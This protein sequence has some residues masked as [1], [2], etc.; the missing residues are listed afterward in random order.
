MKRWLAFGLWIGLAHAVCA[1]QMTRVNGETVD[2]LVFGYARSQWVFVASDGKEV[3]EFSANVRRLTLDPAPKVSVELVNKRHESVFFKG[4]EK[5]A[6]ILGGE[7]GEITAPV[8][9]LKEMKILSRPAAPDPDPEPVVSHSETPIEQVAK[10]VPAVATAPQLPGTGP[11]QW[12]QQG[13]WREMQTPGLRILS[14]GEDVDIESQLRKGVV[15]VIHF[16]YAQAHS[17]VRQG[18]YVEVLSRKSGGRVVVQRIVAP[19]WNAP[20]CKAKELKTLPQFWFYSRSGAL[21]SKLTE[22]FTEAD[23]EAALRKALQQM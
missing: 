11:R 5:F 8:T 7:S 2:G 17:S 10:T 19:D 16:H 1:D 20:I 6:L 22:R 9:L 4:Y 3:R 14:Q 21:S 13:K 18:N 23:I 12:N 15:N